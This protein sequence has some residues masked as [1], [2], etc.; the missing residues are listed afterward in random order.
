MCDPV[1]AG[2]IIGGTAS[3]GA[4]IFGGIQGNKAANALARAQ[5][6]A[7]KGQFFEDQ[8]RVNLNYQNDLEAIE[9]EENITANAQA[10]EEA[11][12]LVAIG[13][14]VPMGNSTN[15]IMQNA[16]A[17]GA[18]NL[19]A[20]QGTAENRRQQA[21]YQYKDNQT[22]YLGKLEEIKGNLNQSFKSGSQLAIEATG[23]FIQGASQGASI[24]SNIQQ[25]QLASAQLNQLESSE[26][27]STV[28]G[29]SSTGSS[30]SYQTQTFQNLAG[31]S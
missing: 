1:T 5:A 16:I 25:G 17:S 2:M 6:N 3:G 4:S 30:G 26:M 24:G 20:L 12:I 21:V 18:L 28:E 11:N 23:A 19:A 15:K 29:M 13:D 10:S 22:N 8:A 14:A 7:A 27:L 31:Q 9:Q